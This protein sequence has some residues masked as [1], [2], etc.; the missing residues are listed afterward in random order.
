MIV[1]VK[2][3]DKEDF[4]MQRAVITG[5]GALT[6]LG[7][8]VKESWQALC[9]G[10]SGIG[11]ITRFDAA[12]FRT[13]IAGEVKGFDPLDFIDRKQVRRV[14]RFIHF[15]LASSRMAIEDSG[16]VIGGDNAERV[17]VSI[18]SAVGGMGFVEK[19]HELILEGGVHQVS[20][21]R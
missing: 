11:P 7:I 3:F 10:R 15:A 19:T 14:D 9:Q 21:A 2:T 17:G 5:L 20:P 6:P 1:N 12:G 16:L 13:R 8:G 4:I 18:G